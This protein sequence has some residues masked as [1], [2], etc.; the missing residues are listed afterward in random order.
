MYSLQQVL[1]HK[2]I[3]LTVDLYGDLRAKDLKDV[4]PLWVL[5][6]NAAICKR[7]IT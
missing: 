3:G 2:Q 5:S 6:D 4:S 1:G 7:N